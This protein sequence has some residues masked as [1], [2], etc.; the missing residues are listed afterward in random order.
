VILGQ[1]HTDPCFQQ[2]YVE[3]YR[4]G[5]ISAITDLEKADIQPCVEFLQHFAVKANLVVPILPREELW[6]L[7]IAHQCATRQWTSF[8]LELLQHLANQMGIA[9]NQA[10]SLEQ[11]IRQ[12]QELRA[13]STALESAVHPQLDTQGRY[14][15][16][17]QAYASMLSYQPENDW[18][19]MACDRPP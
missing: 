19:G 12:R 3:R 18:A 1:S 17:N 16:V 10:H 8:E 15:I 13:M 9:L 4:Q 5:R 14:I 2:G 6:G 11:E 7:L